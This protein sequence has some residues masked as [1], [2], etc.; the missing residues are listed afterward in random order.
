MEIHYNRKLMTSHMIIEQAKT[1]KAWEEEMIANTSIEGILFAECVCENGKNTLWYDITGK[2][3]LD[4]VADASGM[5]YEGL[6]NLLAGLYRAIEQLEGILLQAD[7]ILLV[8]EGIFFDY[9]TDQIWFC[10]CLGMEK[11]L[12]EAFEELMQYLLTK[13]NHEDE[14]AVALIYSVYER[15]AKGGGSLKELKE[16]LKMPY[17]KEDE[18]DAEEMSEEVDDIKVIEEE[19]EEEDAEEEEQDIERSI[20]REEE[21]GEYY[22]VRLWKK[23][24]S[25]LGKRCGKFWKNQKSIKKGMKKVKKDKGEEIYVFE[26]EEEVE[27]K[28]RP[29]VLLAELTKQPEGILRYEGSGN[30][31]DLEIKE[32]VYIIGS[33][34]CCRGYIPS[35]TVSRKHAKITR[36]DGIYFIEDLNSS[37]GTYVGGEMLNYK[38]KV[39][40]QKNEV[41]IF[42]DEKFRFI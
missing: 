33:E 42:A 22:L 4:T 29:T 23:A 39:S 14:R 16:L 7:G 31:K 32:D 21:K 37:N 5:G 34:S 6:V 20:A 27:Q 8:P 19:R 12:P 36:K 1:L 10:Y 18:G 9:R 15:T 3:S 30:G 35:T 40:L 38:T 25:V 24:S 17:K 28:I 26:P 11:T 13:T 2:Q 41:V